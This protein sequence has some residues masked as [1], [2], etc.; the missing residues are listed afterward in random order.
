L[1]AVAAGRLLAL[2]WGG[3][4]IGRFLGGF[5]LRIFQ[6]G[7]VLATFAIIAISLLVTSGFSNGMLAGYALVAVGLFNSLMFPTIFSLATADL[8][9]QAPQASGILC[10]AIVGGA[11]VPPLFGLVADAATLRVALV[12]PA[13]C[14][15][16]IASFGVWSTRQSGVSRSNSTSLCESA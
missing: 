12:V 3:A 15:L 6:P 5:I 7:L 8:T 16:I 9:D 4:M 10:T 1:S 11:L 14:Y 13:V 2:Y